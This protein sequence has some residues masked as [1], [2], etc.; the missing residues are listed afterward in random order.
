[1][2]A[3]LTIEHCSLFVISQVIELYEIRDKNKQNYPC[4]FTGS[5]TY[6]NNEIRRTIDCYAHA[7]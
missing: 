2:L 4:F 5:Q 7:L 1:M 3:A 6:E